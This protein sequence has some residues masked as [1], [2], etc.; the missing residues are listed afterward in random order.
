[1]NYEMD[2]TDVQ[3]NE[4]QTVTVLAVHNSRGLAFVKENE[5]GRI[6][7]AKTGGRQ[8]ERFTKVNMFNT[9]VLY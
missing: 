8:Y 5:T 1:M 4:L 2:G 3:L 9:G 6:R 7:T